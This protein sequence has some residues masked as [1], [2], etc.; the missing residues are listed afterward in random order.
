MGRCLLRTEV[1]E[2]LHDLILVFAV[3]FRLCK[4]GS[5][6]GVIAA[7]LLVHIHRARGEESLHYLQMPALS[8]RVQWSATA[9]DLVRIDFWEF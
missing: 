1:A 4:H 5:K 7:V 3:H 6:W 2:K 8:G 9:T